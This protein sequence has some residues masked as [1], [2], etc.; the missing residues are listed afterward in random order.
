ML[1]LLSSN[2]DLFRIFS[3]L[4]RVCFLSLQISEPSSLQKL[5]LLLYHFHDAFVKIWVPETGRINVSNLFFLAWPV[6]SFKSLKIPNIP[7][8]NLI[9]WSVTTCQNFIILEIQRITCK[10]RAIE[11]FDTFG[12]T[13]IPHVNHWVPPSWN[14]GILINKFDAEYSVWMSWI[15]PL[16]PS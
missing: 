8:L 9:L 5:Q 2:P 13:D 10:M 6:Q 16:G 3:K 12:V 15:I 11:W 1:H 7:Q 14:Q 4:S